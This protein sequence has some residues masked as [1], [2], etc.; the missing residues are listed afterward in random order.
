MKA[1]SIQKTEKRY[2][3]FTQL[4]MFLR[5]PLQYCFRYMEG[6]KIP[7]SGAMVQSRVWHE[8]LENNYRQKICSDTDLPLSNMQ[9]YF[10]ARFD[11]AFG[12]EEVKFEESENPGSL[13][14]QGVSIVSTHHKIIAPRVRPAAVEEEF[15]ISL[16]DDFPYELKGIWDL[17][18]A[19]GTIVDN[20]AYRKTPSQ[21]EL[22]KDL[23]FTVY[24]LGYRA[25]R[26]QIETGIRMDAIIKNKQPKAIQLRTSRNNVDCRWLLSLI[27]KV[28][29]AIQAG[30]FYPNPSGWHCSPRFCGYWEKCKR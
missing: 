2:L 21:D 22:D 30:V 5:C 20:K 1:T 15:R 12:R 10:A 27:E 14:D 26:K 19:D 28:V 4:S 29:Q 16:G 6:L 25:S 13:K 7:P 9:E 17:I 18:E 3:S 23:Q 11:E 24:S 8:T